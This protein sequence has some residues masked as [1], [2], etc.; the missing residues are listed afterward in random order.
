MCGN[1]WKIRGRESVLHDEQQDT[2]TGAW[3]RF[4]EVVEDAAARQLESFSPAESLDPEDWHSIVTLPSTIAKLK[5]VK[6]FELYGSSLVRIPPEIGEMSALE[7]FVPYTSYRLHWFPYEITR[8]EKLKAS[9]VS[10]RALYGNFKYRLAFPDLRA[11]VNQNALKITRP[12]TCSVCNRPFSGERI[13]YRW[14]SLQ[15]A[16]DVLPLLVYACSNQCVD[17]LP[18]PPDNYVKKPH[19]G[20]RS[21]EQPK[22]Y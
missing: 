8:C 17:R 1:A 5:S 10:T 18:V 21:L 12:S 14:I 22:R 4:L 3:K 16:T 13:K 2:S 9:L 20:G 7:G 15:V 6:R 19:L 11:D